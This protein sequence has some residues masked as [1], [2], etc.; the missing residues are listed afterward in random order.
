VVTQAKQATS[1]D[2]TKFF[3]SFKPIPV[4]DEELVEAAK[5]A[6]ANKE[7]APPR[8]IVVSSGV[9]EAIAIK[10]VQAIYP[11][12]AKAAG[13]SGQVQIQILVS[14]KGSVLDA[15]TVSGHPLLRGAALDAARMWVFQPTEI[16]GI[17]VK[18]QGILLF[19]FRLP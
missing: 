18:V 2:V 14:E 12:E 7:K 1:E 17:P 9:L 4:T 3:D 11:P 16:G 10:K 5:A 13:A 15:K 8:K 6:I 19:K